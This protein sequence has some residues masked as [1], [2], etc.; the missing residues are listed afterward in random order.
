MNQS[1]GDVTIISHESTTGDCL[2]TTCFVLGADKGMELIE[3]L[4]G[5]EAIFMKNDGTKLY[6]SYASSYVQK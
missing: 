2:S 3:S 6:S 5:I 4:D 1:F